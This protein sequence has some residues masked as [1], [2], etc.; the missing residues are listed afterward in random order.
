MKLTAQ[1]YDDLIKRR[2][3]LAPLGE[4]EAR[5]PKP[6][7]RAA[8]EC[9][10]ASPQSRVASV[11]VGPFYRV[12]LVTYRKRLQDSDNAI[13]SLKPLRDEI[14]RW[15]GLDDADKF[16]AWEYGQHLTRGSEGVSVK[17]ERL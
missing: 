15:L 2:P 12:T 1:E 13:A 14:A 10:D 5:I 11:A 4:L 8:L 9:G 17:I 3:S 6:H 16:I 7:A